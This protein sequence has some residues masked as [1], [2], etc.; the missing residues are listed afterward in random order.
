V[1]QSGGDVSSIKFRNYWALRQDMQNNRGRRF[2]LWM[3]KENEFLAVM[4]IN[5]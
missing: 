2:P 3:A 5:V 1:Q 4:L